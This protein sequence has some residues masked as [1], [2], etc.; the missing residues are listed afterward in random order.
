MPSE[1][2]C[3]WIA[4]LS[5]NFKVRQAHVVSAT[6]VHIDL[7]NTEGGKPSVTNLI[8]DGEVDTPGGCGSFPAHLVAGLLIVDIVIASVEQLPVDQVV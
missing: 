3:F 2:P 4:R 7:D 5:I 6:A 8:V 1:L